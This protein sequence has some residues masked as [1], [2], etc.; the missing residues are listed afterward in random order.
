MQKQ[1]K[2]GCKLDLF[3]VNREHIL[4]GANTLEVDLI[5]TLILT[6]K[7][8]D[9]Y[10]VNREHILTGAYTIDTNLIGMLI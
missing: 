3:S 1:K 9:L 6:Q 5:G 7:G 8:L 2:R 10:S 4:T